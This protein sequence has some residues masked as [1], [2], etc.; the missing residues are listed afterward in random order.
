MDVNEFG[1]E[2]AAPWT[3]ER[4]VLTYELREEMPPGTVFGRVRA[5]DRDT[6]V[7]RYQ[8]SESEYIGLNATTGETA[9][10]R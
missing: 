7:R 3:P 2:F 4:P 5:T 9:R 1:P 6:Q 10:Q 8:A